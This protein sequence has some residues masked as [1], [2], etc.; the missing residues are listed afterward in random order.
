MFSPARSSW[1]PAFVT[2][3]T[4]GWSPQAAHFIGT[5]PANGSVE[6]VNRAVYFPLIVPVTTIVRRVFWANGTSPSGNGD[7]GIYADAGG[8][9]GTLLVSA[10]TT[11]NSGSNS[12]QFVDVTDTTLSPG[13]YWLAVAFSNGQL[14]R[15]ATSGVTDAC[16][17]FQENV[18]PLPATATPVESSGT[19]VYLFGFA[20]TASP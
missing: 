12:L 13:R 20:T 6:A 15:S 10:G 8:K 5:P 3:H 19:N 9:P 7:V 14:F 18:M 2:T 17:R 11:A 16:V 4:P 1:P